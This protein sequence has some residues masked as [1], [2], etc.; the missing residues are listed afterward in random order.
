MLKCENGCRYQHSY[1]LAV[2]Y[3]LEC[4]SYS[5]L[6]FSESYVSAYKTVHRTIILH[7]SLYG[8][9]CC[10]LIRGIFIHE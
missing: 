1:L 8:S 2:T 4:R 3:C 9:G 6:G 10:L 7:I 5:K